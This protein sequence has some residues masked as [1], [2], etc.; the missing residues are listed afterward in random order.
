MTDKI[1][2]NGIAQPA[3]WPP[4]NQIPS[5]QPMRVPYLEAPPAVIP[6][7]VGRQLFVDDFLIES[8]S[9]A[10]AYHRPVKYPGNPVFFPQ[11]K[12]ERGTER[13]PTTI[14]KCG[15]LWHDDRDQLFKMW[16]MASYLGSMAYA[17]SEDGVHWERP[18]LDVVPGTN[19]ILPDVPRPDSGT[20][21][22]DRETSDD[23]QRYKFM[24]RQGDS[25]EVGERALMM[26]SPDGVHWSKPA[27][28]GPMGDRSTMFYN[29][30]R[31]K[32][33]QSIRG[34]QHPAGRMRRYWEAEEFFESGRWK[35]GE[36]PFWTCAD[37]MDEGGATPPQLYNLDAT[38]YES[39]MLGLFQIHKG[40]D[41]G[42]CDAIGM[43]KLTELV[44]A[45]SRDGFH[46]HRPDRHPF[47]GARREP[48]SWEYG[49]IEPTGGL[50]LI[51][52]DELW[53]YYSAY[54]GD[55]GRAHGGGKW[56]LCGTY[57]NGALGLAKLRR[58]G[59][60]SMQA[61]QPGASLT[62]KPLLFNGGRLFVNAN[63]A[64]S[65]L[66]VECLDEKNQPI[67]PFTKQR[68]RALCGNSVCSEIR[69]DGTESLGAMRDKPIKLRFQ[70]DRG[71]LY[72]F[73]ITDSPQGASHGH[74]AAGGPGLSGPTDE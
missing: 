21:W 49:Y 44:L 53:F 5:S 14:P 24:L 69:W 70:F 46:W 33:V 31:R 57:S 18:S 34:Y 65:E 29:P 50:C 28:T 48:G 6:V 71:D 26:T 12:H 43:P 72:S 36:P 22:L 38:P 56:E 17:T 52:G 23:S 19:L 1:S 66:T 59:F 73:W 68:C 42:I 7:D 25:P 3:E 74:L 13:P 15:G 47:I 20:V 4:K 10:R 35:G 30:F 16:Y 60:V 11:T 27:S 2:Y 67:E 40:P 41:N 39:L 64:G 61:R 51:V 8:N 63:T 32:W 54:A 37:C 45:T 62:T 55:P 58:D 9:M